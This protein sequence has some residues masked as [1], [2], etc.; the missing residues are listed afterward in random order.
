VE[1]IGFRPVDMEG[2]VVSLGRPTTVNV[3]LA[4][5]PIA[6]A[7]VE[8]EAQRIRLV[9]PD[10]SATRQILIG[11]ELRSLPI[12]RTAEAVELTPGVSGGHFRGGRIGQEVHV[13]DG[14]E[15]KNQLEAS[16]HGPGLEL[17]PGAL[18]EIEVVTGGI[19]A[20]Y[21]SA[22]SG[23]ISYVTRRGDREQWRGRASVTTDQWAPESLF[24]G[25]T[26]LSLAAGGPVRLLGPGATLY[27]DVLGQGM[28]DADPRGR[29]LGCLDESDAAPDVAALITQVRSA[30]PDLY[31]P[32]TG[33]SLPHQSGDKRIGFARLDVPLGGAAFT[34]TAL[35]NRLQ[36][37]LYTP[38]LKYSRE[39]QLG[40]RA[41]GGMLGAGLD[42]GQQGDGRARHA[43][44]RVGWV[45]LD[46][47]LGAVDPSSLDGRV[48]ISGFG[49]SAFEFLGEQFVRRPI[50]EQLADPGAVPGYGAPSGLDSPFGP[51][52]AG[53]F[54][55][56]G[57]P[58]VANWTRSDALSV[59]VV[60]ELIGASG[61]LVR[62]G[63]SARHYQVESYERTFAHLAGSLPSYA[64]FHPASVAAFVEGRLAGADE[65]T[66]NAG[67]RFEAFRSGVEFR[68]DRDDFLSPT[69]D[70]SWQLALMPRLGIAL[71]V[72]GTDGR[73]ALR[74]SY[75]HVAQAPD[76]RFFLDT[77]IGDSTRRAVSRQG[78]PA[79]SFERGR[80]FELAGSQVLGENVGAT[81]TVFRK[82]LQDLASGNVQVG[83]SGLPQYSVNDYGTVQGVELSLRGGWDDVSVR[84]GYTLQKATGASS[85]SDSDTTVIVGSDVE[86]RPLA[87]DQRHAIDVVLLGGEAA[88]NAGSR[89]SFALTGGARSGYPLT[90]RAAAG[91]TLLAFD[92]YLP[93]TVTTDL[94]VA[95]RPGALP[96]CGSCE[97]RVVA[98]ARNLLGRENVLALRPASGRLAP[99]ADELAA[100]EMSV[101]RPGGPIP[102]ESSL[103]RM[104]IDADRDG[105][106]TLAEFDAASRAAALDRFDPSL[107]IGPPRSIRLG[108]EVTF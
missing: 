7:G 67:L 39:A 2:I 107:M 8:V 4:A 101:P 49:M 59:D 3:H 88:G 104:S 86:E 18:E 19:P 48:E 23:V 44:V 92:G 45:R 95:W 65:L 27:V 43:S 25:F 98:D 30:T 14:L 53:L 46:R 29:G 72:P 9:E 75:G 58:S 55:T 76:F 78:N 13:V 71:P 84:L 60:G 94:R 80:T 61:G 36:R 74:F 103:Y 99:S 34:F 66:L 33:E 62:G 93:W 90:R 24:S 42:F 52:G 79:I 73:S 12:D 37:L 15:V 51:A 64:R 100:V 83:S 102:S 82:E 10:V 54:F 17:P 6:V 28:A 63:A 32:Y 50:E 91:D 56:S 41:S 5:A 20:A 40:Q 26:A 31:C 87:F 16:A 35:T 105:T 69:I 106:I 1:R 81:V 68:R 77:A 38:E 97:W 47:Y 21:G 57:T 22:L 70:P 89:W 96:L 85:G 11:R 108:I